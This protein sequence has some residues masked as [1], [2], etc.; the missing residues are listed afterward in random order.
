M[1]RD[2]ELLAYLRRK[3]CAMGFGRVREDFRWPE[4]EL[5]AVLSKLL[6]QRLIFCPGPRQYQAVE[7]TVERTPRRDREPELGPPIAAVVDRARLL[8]PVKPVEAKS[9]TQGFDPLV[10]KGPRQPDPN[11]APICQPA[12]VPTEETTM[13]K[14]KKTCTKCNQPKGATAYSNGSDVCRFCEKGGTPKPQGGVGAK[15][16]GARKKANG[17]TLRAIAARH[18]PRKNGDGRFA[19]TIAELRAEAAKLTAAA[20]QLEALG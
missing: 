2:E 15:R 8:G 9:V 14:A 19:A 16:A 11:S 13:A 17:A 20:D 3:R 12:P 5:E 6:S 1:T 7:E 4:R 10:D 18:A